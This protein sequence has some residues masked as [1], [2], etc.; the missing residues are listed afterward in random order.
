MGFNFPTLDQDTLLIIKLG[1]LQFLAG[2]DYWI[3]LHSQYISLYWS[4]LY[5]ASQGTWFN[6][7]SSSTTRQR[8]I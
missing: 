3:H 7:N 2:S 5:Q 4:N 8:N 1:Q 6:F